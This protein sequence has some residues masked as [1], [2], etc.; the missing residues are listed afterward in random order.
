MASKLFIAVVAVLMLL[1]GS[2]KA[3]DVSIIDGLKKLP[4]VKQGM[5][6]SIDDAKLNYLATIDLASFKGFNFEGGV[7]TD[8]EKTGTKA[9]ALLSYDLFNAK[10]FGITM[11]IL[12]LIDLRPGLWAGYGRI[13]GFQDGQL[14]GEGSWGVSCTAMTLKW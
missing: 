12:D 8:A 6:F 4:G 11:P 1:T 3:E 5:A 9:V 14:K 7:A 13:E 10:K 2:S